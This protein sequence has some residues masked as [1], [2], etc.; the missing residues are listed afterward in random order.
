[1]KKLYTKIFLQL[2][3]L[4]FTLSASAQTK[5]Q[6]STSTTW[7]ASQKEPFLYGQC[8]DCIIEIAPGATL[9][10]NK[11]LA[12][13][14][15]IFKG[16]NLVV[17]SNQMNIYN[18][19]TT[20][21]NDI[22]VSFSGTA[23]LM[24]SGPVSAKNARFKFEQN[25]KLVGQFSLNFDNTILSFK[26]RAN[27][28]FTGS[29]VNLRNNSRI[30]I[31]DG[32]SNSQSMF[33]MN[34]QRLNIYDGSK[35][36]LAT[37][38]NKY[39]SWGSFYI[40]P[41]GR[42][43]NTLSNKLNCGT[44]FPNACAMDELYGP[45]MFDQKGISTLSILP[46]KLTD[47]TVRATANQVQINWATAQEQQSDRFIVQRSTDQNNWIDAGTVKA[48][49]TSTIRLS[50]SF[51]DRHAV[52]GQ[53]YYRL[54]MVDLDGSVEYSPIRQVLITAAETKISIFPNPTTDYIQVNSAGIKGQV[55]I[56]L[57]NAYGQV[58]QTKQQ[59]GGSIATL[60]VGQ[61]TKGSYYVR[62]TDNSGKQES[63]KLM[64]R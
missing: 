24:G 51:T 39:K 20:E 48:A 46:V 14:K 16:G 11:N 4:V 31:G 8:I 52:A 29:E 34:G 25:T 9:T 49:G 38:Y 62:I 33:W 47:L 13:S 5:I 45:I 50:Y 18:G 21:F 35:V 53:V 54:K 10:I 6:I 27:L 1:M 57:L 41:E 60:S 7:S 26:D 64:I 55:K 61:F 12:F 22:D 30:E 28:E 36:A 56:E 37:S 59:P 19:G 15:T 42:F 58:V 23:V 44:G 2:V 63:L 40:M 3:L 32:T 17:K 43:V